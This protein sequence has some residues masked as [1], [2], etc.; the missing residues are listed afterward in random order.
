ML[1]ASRAIK[2]NI[3]RGPRTLGTYISKHPYRFGLQCAGYGTAVAVIGALSTVPYIGPLAPALMV[4]MMGGT[5][6]MTAIEPVPAKSLLILCC[7]VALSSKAVKGLYATGLGLSFHATSV[8]LMEGVMVKEDE[9]KLMKLFRKMY[10]KT[11]LLEQSKCKDA[12]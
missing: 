7:N 9:E 1:T 8:E 4:P 10:R 3:K 5:E 2:R 11:D 6:W 12:K